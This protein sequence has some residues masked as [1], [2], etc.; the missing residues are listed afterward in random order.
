MSV[1]FISWMRS[2]R[3]SD[4]LAERLGGVS[5]LVH[6]QGRTRNLPGPARYPGQ[7]VTTLRHLVADRPGLVVV[8][9]PPFPATLVVWAYSRIRRV[10][11]VVDAHSGIFNDRKWRWARPIS[12]MVSRGARVTIVTGEH[13]RGAVEG[14]GARAV[15]IGD[16]PV[17]FPDV[18]P[19]DLG[20]GSHIVMP[21][22]FA[23]DEPLAQVLAALR[24]VP[25]ITLHMTGNAAKAGDL[26]ADP[27]GNLRLT[28]FVAEDE[29]AA[30]LR[31]ADAV[32]VLTT[33]DH[34]M[35]RGG[36]EAMALGKP[37]ITSDWD[38]LRETFA[39]GTIHVDNS[40][41]AIAEAMRAVIGDGPQ[42][43]GQ[44]AELRVNRLARFERRLGELKAAVSGRRV[45]ASA[46]N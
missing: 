46:A 34:T 18:A 31:G 38:L 37:L 15:V 29:Y 23:W 10:P 28:G 3:R 12:R 40:P 13:Y 35:Q 41:A 4:A 14:W 17:T 20:P 21:C 1:S 6:S 24:E 19:A 36:Y 26:L 42:L 2:C 25:E 44:M 16:V 45:G 39:A 30:L 27:P 33:R 11:Y 5:H 32:M 8:A 9:A 43:A 22:S 7:A